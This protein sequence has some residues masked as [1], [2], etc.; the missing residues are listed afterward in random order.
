MSEYS[1]HGKRVWVA[2]HRGMVGSAVAR[3][4]ASEPVADLVMATSDELD[5]RNQAATH[6][7]VADTLPDVIVLAAGKVGGIRANQSAQGEFL[8]DN[9]MIAANVLEAARINDVER[10]VN[11]GS[12]CIYPMDAAQPMT[13][14]ALLTGR[15]DE[16]NEGYAIAKITALELAKMYRRQYGLNAISLM[17]SN[18]YG[19]DD[20]F[21]LRTSHVLAALLRKIH[22][23]KIDGV[24]TVP[25][26]GTGTPR[27]EFLHVDDLANAT[28]FALEHYDAEEHLNVGTGSD[29]AISELADIIA[30]IVGYQGD[31]VYDASMPDGTPRKLLDVTKLTELGWSA[32]I[33]LE[34]GIASTY[35]LYLQN[36]A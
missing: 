29:V 17:P 15:L 20:N 4:L 19:P 31:F 14:D 22:E 32:S 27:R 34:Q 7:F 16:S 35:D 11:L 10:V 9:L 24:G 1:L 18:L 13:E 6:A 23:A 25:I 12:S 2:G 33:G 3:R 26:W 8:Y 28:V 21:D 5:L 30:K 36:R